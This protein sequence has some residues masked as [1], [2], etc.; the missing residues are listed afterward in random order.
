MR[1]NHW[2]LLYRADNLVPCRGGEMIR[3]VVFAMVL[4]VG[5]CVT[6]REIYF[7]DGSKGHRIGCEGAV[8][9]L[10]SCFDKAGDICEARGYLV[11]NQQG[12]AVRFATASGG[13]VTQSGTLL[14]KCK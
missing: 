3:I 12:E 8:Q 7:A 5:G 6:S 4:L 11:V 13:Y 9:Y 2:W 14:V 1:D 10:G